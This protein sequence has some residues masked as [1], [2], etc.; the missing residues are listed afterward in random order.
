MRLLKAQLR[1]WLSVCS[2]NRDC[3]C[4][5]PERPPLP[6]GPRPGC[7]LLWGARW[8]TVRNTAPAPGTMRRSRQGWGV[9]VPASVRPQASS[10]AGDDLRKAALSRPRRQARR[11]GTHGAERPGAP[12]APPPGRG[13]GVPDPG[14]R[15]FHSFLLSPGRPFD[16]GP[17]SRAPPPVGGLGEEMGPLSWEEGDGLGAGGGDWAFRGG[18]P[19]SL[20]P[21]GGV[22]RVPPGIAGS[23]GGGPSD[24]GA[25]AG[26]PGGSPPL[27]AQPRGDE[28]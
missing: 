28:T 20:Q 27:W 25:G 2:V 6:P 16:P 22:L 18:C 13:A 24:A 3:R 7:G 8:G 9:L 17:G 12:G 19:R 5:G 1:A 21:S 4:S 15:A 26:P 14:G 10:G 11:P 23:S